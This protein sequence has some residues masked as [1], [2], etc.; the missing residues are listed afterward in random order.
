[1]PADGVVDVTGLLDRE[2]IGSYQIRVAALCAAVVFLDGFDT[3]VIGNLVPSIIADFKVTRPAMAPV[4]MAGLVGLMVGALSLSP[5]ADKI[6]RR[7]VIVGS[8]LA[9]GVMTLLTGL[10]AES[11]TGLVVL[12]FLTGLG[13]GGAMPNAI[14]MTAEYAPRRRQATMVMVM[15][16]GFPLGA[17][18][19]GFI[20]AYLIPALGWRAV[21]Y[22]GGVLPIALVPL[23]L[24]ELPESIRHLVLQGNQ[25]AR[26]AAI[27]ARI[28]PGLAFPHGTRFAI[29][30]QHGHG[31]PVGH[32]FREG[33][34]APT[35]L[36]W[37]VFFMSLLNIFLINFWLPTLTHD[38]GVALAIANMATG[39]FQA[40]GV[41]STLLGGRAVDA[42]GAY[43]VLS[44]AYFLAALSIGA[45]GFA[46]VS[47]ALLLIVGTV[48]GFCLIGGQTGV[49]ALS[50]TFYPTFIRSTGVGWALGIGRIGSIAGPGVG[51]ILIALKW[52]T[53]AI[54]IIGAVAALCAAVALFAMGRTQAARAQLAAQP[55][56]APGE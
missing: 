30:E 45:L 43:R 4:G 35:V 47:P 33:R 29:G 26:I 48:A 5:L 44:P 16:C 32:L 54:F 55:S 49:N 56:L 22:L 31:V 21:L 38:A 25:T 39:L 14:A 27:L 2:K 41:I 34:A 19:A 46:V 15:F 40:G 11:V 20:S 9:F 18:F 17:S 23:L 28:S 36:L 50:S 42:F 10:L 37:I 52:P 7:G 3:Q 8:T 51:G 12:R 24:A 6:G 13:L 1:M 53:A